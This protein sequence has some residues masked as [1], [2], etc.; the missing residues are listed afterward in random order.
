MINWI[1]I[2]L[3]KFVKCYSMRFS[4]NAYPEEVQNALD[5]IASDDLIGGLHDGV[6][7]QSFLK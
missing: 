7:V 1:K 6:D 5:D 3:A 2:K 4:S